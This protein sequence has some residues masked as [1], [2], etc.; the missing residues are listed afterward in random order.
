VIEG[1]M[2]VSRKKEVLETGRID[3][4]VVLGGGGGRATVWTCDLT[5]GYVEV[6]I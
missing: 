1:G 4:E 3:M 6:N 5:P 2:I